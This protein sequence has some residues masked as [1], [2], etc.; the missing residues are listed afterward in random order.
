MAVEPPAR[1]LGIAA[2]LLAAAEDAARAR[3][4]SYIALMVTEKTKP[5]ANS[6][7]KPAS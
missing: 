4:L 6:T 7:P 2:H 1:R 3:G 5:P